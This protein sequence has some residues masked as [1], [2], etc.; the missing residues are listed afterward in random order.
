[1]PDIK[2]HYEPFLDNPF[3]EKACAGEKCW[4]QAQVKFTLDL[5]QE[6]IGIINDK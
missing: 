4:F 1:M 5:F 6:F 2:I 3:L